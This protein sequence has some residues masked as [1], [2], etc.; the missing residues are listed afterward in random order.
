MTRALEAAIATAGAESGAAHPVT[1]VRQG[2]W[3]L[4][5]RLVPQAAG[6]ALLV[7]G[8]RFLE[9]AALGSFV[10]A[11]AGI[12]L[13]RQFVRAGWREAVLLGDPDSTPA[14]TFLSLVGA[15]AATPIALA[16]AA[17]LWRWTD[18]DPSVPR[19]VAILAATLPALA[20][21]VVWEGV[22]LRR[23]RTEAAAKPLIAAEAA[24]VAVALL[25]L[26]TG[27]GILA[28]AWARLA[29][30]AVLTV[31][32]GH[33]ARWPLALSTDL[34]RAA[35]VLPL[36]ANVT[37]QSL[38]GFASSSG[39]DLVVGLYLGPAS[40]AFWRIG[41]RVAGALAETVAETVRV[42]AWSVFAAEARRGG[43]RA[44]LAERVGTFL[45]QATVLV[46]PL[47]IGLALVAEP[48]ILLLMGDAWLAAGQVIALR[49]LAALFQAPSTVAWPA[50]A[51]L[52]KTRLLPRL[53]GLVAGSGIL[54]VV[55]FAPRGL[56]A[57]AWSQLAAALV[58]GLA[59]LA[60][61]DRNLS[62]PARPR[63]DILLGIAA[64]AVAVL[65]T[66]HLGATLP[67]AAVL[68]A[69]A[70]AGTLAWLA[71]LRLRRRELLYA[72]TQALRR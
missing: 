72:L 64:L 7:L 61:L 42:L 5:S 41:S 2:G 53:T 60:I 4:A 21:S 27:H 43:E 50:L 57:V 46:A 34:S 48:L 47:F 9:P 35:A 51:L 31:G 63:A 67:P 44:A 19:C 45:D 36:S 32:L 38:I 13:L 28:L 68:L 65:A 24:N 37:L 17:A 16:T 11:F 55:L 52:G 30:A 23:E 25:L 6:V 69:Q 22:L 1:A 66:G 3:V 8:G 40:V 58:G 33:A 10:L 49:A 39:T 70:V 15:L 14:V 12:E 56:M 20:L 71:F 59:V 26:S 18:L 62:V 54:M 29:R